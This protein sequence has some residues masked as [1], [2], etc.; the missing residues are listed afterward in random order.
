MSD[1]SK[2]EV[3]PFSFKGSV[4]VPKT[5]IQ[6]IQGVYEAYAG[7]LAS[8]ISTNYRVNTTAVVLSVNQS[9]FGE[10]KETLQSPSI[11]GIVNMSP[12]RGEMII[13]VSPNLVFN[14][15]DRMLGGRGELISLT[16]PLTD[17]EMK[18]VE[19]ILRGFTGD[20]KTALRGIVTTDAKLT[21]VLTNPRFIQITSG[22]DICIS[23]SIEIKI[24]EITGIVNICAP[25]AI[26]DA[27]MEG[28]SGEKSTSGQ[29]KSI[30]NL[31]TTHD[32][33]VK[34][35][36]LMKGV[37]FPFVVAL[38]QINTKASDVMNLQVG[39]II[40]LN[41]KV[42]DYLT[43]T[44]GDAPKYKCKPGQIGSNIAVEIIKVLKKQLPMDD[45]W[46]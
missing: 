6:G 22:S 36:E 13:E 23:G 17:I 19:E 10:F 44:V 18:L 25:S 28:L 26:I 9:S 42:T 2:K 45:D 24:G 31:I 30:Q 8:S 37:E 41:T 40:R 46:V 4:Q 14:F 5:Q 7:K 20:L 21:N 16:R 15:I 32:D 11:M 1:K 34:T 27:I 39:D 29:R 35:K 38:G 12:M 3:K 43:A 33:Q